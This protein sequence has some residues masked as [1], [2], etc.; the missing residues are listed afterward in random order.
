MNAKE[1]VRELRQTFKSGVTKSSP[2]P[3]PLLPRVE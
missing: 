2:A 3:Q 1:T